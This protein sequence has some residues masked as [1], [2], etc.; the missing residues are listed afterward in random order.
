MMNA[1]SNSRLRQFLL[2]PIVPITYLIGALLI[3][4]GIGGLAGLEP[5]APTWVSVLDLFYGALTAGVGWWMMVAPANP[6]PRW[7]I[8]FLNIAGCLAG[9][10]MLDTSSGASMLIMAPALITV[11]ASG[12]FAAL[13]LYPLFL[14]FAIS[15][16]RS[17]GE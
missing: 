10:I 17:G 9:L 14:I 1:S 13:F 12:Q 11:M 7:I 8:S 16:G 3:I 4:T 6:Q 15:I 5:D 2:D